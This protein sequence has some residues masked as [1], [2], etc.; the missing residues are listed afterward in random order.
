[1]DSAKSNINKAKK[2]LETPLDI[3]QKS[4]NISGQD[5]GSIS[6]NILSIRDAELIILKNID[7]KFEGQKKDSKT[8]SIISSTKEIINDA[9][10]LNN[11]NSIDLLKS[12]ILDNAI[13]E[14]INSG[15]VGRLYL[16]N[17]DLI[18]KIN[19]TQNWL[20]EFEVL[21]NKQ[22]KLFSAQL[23]ILE[24]SR[25]NKEYLLN[26]ARM[27]LARAI[28]ITP[29]KTGYL[30]RSGFVNETDYGVLISFA[31]PY[32]SYVHENMNNRHP[33]GQ[34]KFL[35]QAAQ[36]FFPDKTIW[37]EYHDSGVIMIYLTYSNKVEY[38]H[39]D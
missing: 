3:I 9:N 25:L 26:V 33:I 18:K 24:M 31:A 11:D 12:K 38:Y 34:A 22:K 8:I 14:V 23:S 20:K 15:L 17:R 2:V 30:R 7:D 21:K 6:K 1:M 28:E 19:S 5:I 37:V 39:Y 27:I 16:G 32:A 13:Y 4:F 10:K 36:E 35:E 29:Y